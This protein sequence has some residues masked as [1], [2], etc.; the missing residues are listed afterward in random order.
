MRATGARHDE[1]RATNDIGE[2]EWERRFGG[3]GDELG[4][5]IVAGADGALTIVG[6]SRTYGT[7]EHILLMK[8]EPV[9]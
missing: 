9:G 3:R 7:S 6:H 1:A 8:L 2:L 4:R 5:S